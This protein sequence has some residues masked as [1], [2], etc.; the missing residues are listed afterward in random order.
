MP[1]SPCARRDV[2]TAAFN[3]S[4]FA[5]L[6]VYSIQRDLVNTNS[7][8]FIKSSPVHFLDI[9]SKS[10]LV[11]LC[12][13]PSQPGQLYRQVGAAVDL[14]AV[15][16]AAAVLRCPEADIIGAG[17]PGLPEGIM[18]AEDAVL[19]GGALLDGIAGL[20]GPPQHLLQVQPGPGQGA[21]V[22]AVRVSA[23]SSTAGKIPCFIV[24]PPLESLIPYNKCTTKPPDFP[25]QAVKKVEIRPLSPPQNRGSRPG[26]FHTPLGK[27]GKTAH[28][29]AAAGQNRGWVYGKKGKAQSA[30]PSKAS[31]GPPS[32]GST[33]DQRA[34]SYSPSGAV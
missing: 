6:S 13:F 34:S 22:Q 31:Q 16:P 20:P 1:A 8:N 17:L 14:I 4:L 25:Q 9:L 19:V 33:A 30:G 26:V 23:S 12:R 2:D 24:L 32:A 29:G 5:L 28:P 7:N 3:Y 11:F 27:P 10:H 21:G 15:K 18:G